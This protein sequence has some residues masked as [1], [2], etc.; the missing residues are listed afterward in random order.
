MDLRPK[1]KIRAREIAES[2]FVVTAQLL[3]SGLGYPPEYFLKV[4]GRLKEHST[5]QGFPKYGYALECDGN[6]VGAIILIFSA[7]QPGIVRCHVTS[8]YVEAAYRAYAALFFSKGLKYSGVTYLNVSARPGSVPIIESQ[9]FK[10]FSSGQF[11]ALPVLN[12]ARGER[13]EVFEATSA[14]GALL[15]FFEWKLLI[16]HAKFGCISVGCLAS[17]RAHPFIFQSRLFKGFIPGVQLIY[18]RGIDDFVRFA[19]PL[20]SYLASRGKLLVSIDSMA[21]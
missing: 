7:A 18:C 4:F 14:P 12:F 16:E 2:D 3:A 8:W 11:I 10:R 6:I 21:Q 20:G 17:T 1:T 5:P 19:R 13:A 15:E 9:G